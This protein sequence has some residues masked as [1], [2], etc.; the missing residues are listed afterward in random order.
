MDLTPYTK[1]TGCKC[2]DTKGGLTQNTLDVRIPGTSNQKLPPPPLHSSSSH[3]EQGSE[4]HTGTCHEIPIL[5]LRL[6]SAEILAE[7]L[8]PA[9]FNSRAMDIYSFLYGST[10]RTKVG[11]L[12]SGD[13]HEDKKVRAAQEDAT[14]AHCTQA[15]T[16]EGSR[17]KG[18]NLRLFKSHHGR[19]QDSIRAS[20]SH[21]NQLAQRPAPMRAG[22]MVGVTGQRCVAGRWFDIGSIHK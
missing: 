16:T 8:R 17:S 1:H 18:R 15:V 7:H 21:L 4:R 6:S 3:P 11:D 20:P 10:S 5:M 12:T 22:A 13:P 19:P 14:G 9:V 2:S